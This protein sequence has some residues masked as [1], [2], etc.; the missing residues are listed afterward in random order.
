MSVCRVNHIML[1][2]IMLCYELYIRVIIQGIDE[3]AQHVLSSHL[4]HRIQF[5]GFVR[6]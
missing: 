2:M 1:E 5:A 4:H 6:S 3:G